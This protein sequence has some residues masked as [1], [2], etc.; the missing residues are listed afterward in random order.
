MQISTRIKIV[1]WISVLAVLFGL[2][3]KM[4]LTQQRKKSTTLTG[5]VISKNADTKKELPIPDAEI[6]GASGLSIGNCKSDASGFFQ[7]TLQPGVQDGSPV[8]LHFR[9]HEYVPLDIDDSIKDKLYVARMLPVPRKEPQAAHPDVTVANLSARY[10]M[11]AVTA[12]NIGSA[13][14]TFQAI[15]VGNVPCGGQHPCSPDGKWRATIASASLDAGEGN[16]FRNARASCIAGPC[17]FTKIESDGFS[18]GGRIINVA[19]RN[20]SDTA[21]FLVEAEVFHSMVSDIVRKSY[22]VIFGRVLN[23]TLPAAAEGVTIQAEINGEP[24]VFPLG[25]SLHL[26]WADCNARVNKD[27]TKVFRC[28]LKEGYQFPS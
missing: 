14:R 7:L 4:R 8:S 2:L 10:S 18:R 25:P 22:P 26:S 13:V 20:W 3:G 5:A 11:K 24:I 17:S 15:N 21:T 16:E 1:V 27:Q 12:V 6:T 19:A 28:E 9:H 23:F